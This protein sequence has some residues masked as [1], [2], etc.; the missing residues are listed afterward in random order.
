[1]HDIENLINKSIKDTKLVKINKNIYLTNYE[2][3]ILKL[4]NISY[5][6]CNNY[7]EILYYIE[8]ELEY[9]DSIEDLEQISLTISERNYYQNTKK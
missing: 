3:E 7:Q 4:Y 6:R 8:E 5:E 1:M 2:I 9:N